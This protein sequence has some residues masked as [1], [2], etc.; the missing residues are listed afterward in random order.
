MGVGEQ[1]RE[2]RKQLGHSLEDVQSATKIR[3]LYLEAIEADRFGDLPGPVYARGFIRS[4]GNF[5]GLDGRALAATAVG[6]PARATGTESAAGDGMPEPAPRTAN[7]AAAAPPPLARAPAP[8]RPVSQPLHLDAPA[9]TPRR[10]WAAVLTGVGALVV[11]GVI[12]LLWLASPHAPGGSH[13]AA[14]T[15]GASASATAS[16]KAGAAGAAT[17]TASP[18]AT[19]TASAPAVTIT[20]TRSAETTGSTLTTFTVA[21]AGSLTVQARASARC[22]IRVSTDATVVTPNTTMVAGQ[23]LTWRARQAIRLRVGYPLGL[24]LTVNGVALPAFSG[25]TAIDVAIVRKGAATP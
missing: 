24:H 12:A 8:R 7:P 25:T 21:G 15:P 11:L 23:R 22:W 4:Y 2:R 18:A 19:T 3:R 10:T 1:L 13:A 17:A 5:L 20:S 6:A 9:R 14:T 16:G